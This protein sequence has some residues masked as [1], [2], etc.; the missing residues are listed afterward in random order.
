MCSGYFD[1]FTVNGS[2]TWEV[3]VPVDSTPTECLTQTLDP[4]KIYWIPPGTDYAAD[5]IAPNNTNP[6]CWDPVTPTLVFTGGQLITVTGLSAGDLGG[7]QFVAGS[8]TGSDPTVVTI[9]GLAATTDR[10]A[11]PAGVIL[12]SALIAVVGIVLVIRRRH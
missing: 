4:G 9:V 1:F 12:V 2:G 5:C 6:G 10:S 7:T 8:T 11:A 3:S